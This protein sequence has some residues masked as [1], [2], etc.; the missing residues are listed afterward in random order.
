MAVDASADADY[1]NLMDDR[2]SITGYVN[3]MSAGPVTWQSKNQTS[4]ALS[5]MEGTIATQSSLP[6]SAFFSVFISP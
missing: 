6:S 3:F 4:V 2:R 1:A 5:T